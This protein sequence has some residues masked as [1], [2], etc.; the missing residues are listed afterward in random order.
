MNKSQGII[1][2]LLLQYF[3]FALKKKVSWNTRIVATSQ[4]PHLSCNTSLNNIKHPSL[5]P[6]CPRAWC[7]RRP[8]RSWGPRR[9]PPSPRRWR[10]SPRP[11]GRRAASPGARSSCSSSR[12]RG[13][14]SW[15]GGKRWSWRRRWRWR[16]GSPA[17]AG[18]RHCVWKI[19]SLIHNNTTFSCRS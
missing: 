6:V 12:S 8:G 14:W 5:S 2:S 13:W 3:Q 15:S 17:A 7:W 1:S 10:C 11:G 16:W 4:L 9:P 19:I 18:P